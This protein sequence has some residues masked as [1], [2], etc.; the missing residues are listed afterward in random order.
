M[1]RMTLAFRGA[2]KDDAS[3]MDVE[4]RIVDIFHEEQLSEEFLCTVN[5]LGQVSNCSSAFPEIGI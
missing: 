1:V 2:P 4:E 3:A 5:E